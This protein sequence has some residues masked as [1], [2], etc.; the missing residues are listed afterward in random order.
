MDSKKIVVA[1]VCVIV[2]IVAIAVLVR[3][4]RE[5]AT[6]PDDVMGMQYHIIDVDSLEVSEITVEEWNR[7][8]E[9]PDTG[10]RTIRGATVSMVVACPDCGE[11][12]PTPPMTEEPP[13]AC[14]RCESE[15]DNPDRYR[16]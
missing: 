8:T 16:P 15:F 10:Y 3:T 1:A 13:H 2:I 11:P 14:P 12:I 4:Q 7:L 5:D 9:D 6:A